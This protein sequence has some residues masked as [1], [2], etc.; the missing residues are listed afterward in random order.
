MP[1]NGRDHPDIPR[2]R[3]LE[4][5]FAAFLQQTHVPG[6]FA[7][8]VRERVR[9]QRARR[10][11]WEGWTN[12]GTWWTHGWL[13]RGVWVATGYGLLSLVLQVSVGLYAWQQMHT[14]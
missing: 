10:G 9:Y 14:V 4:E 1:P 2:D 13:P 6:D 3:A 11:R 7:A 8:G 5:A 12:V